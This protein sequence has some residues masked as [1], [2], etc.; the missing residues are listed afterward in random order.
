VRSF[1]QQA[2]AVGQDPQHRELLVTGDLAQPGRPGGG[3]RDRVRVGLT[4]LA[5]AKDLGA[6]R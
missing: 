3:Q 2:A 6:G 4:A 5:G 1:A